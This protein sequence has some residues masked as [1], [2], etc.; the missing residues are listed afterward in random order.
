MGKDSSYNSISPTDYRYQ[1]D[2]LL[3]FLSEEAFVKYKSKVEAALALTLAKRRIISQENADKIVR[4]ASKVTAAE[5]YE[6]EKETRHDIIAQVNMI[7]KRLKGKAKS[8]VHMT[9]T[10]FDIVETANAMRYRDAFSQYIISDMVS[11]EKTWIEIARREKDTLQIGRTH[12]QHGEP[13]TYGFAMAWYVDRF[14][15]GILN[16][17]EAVEGLRGKFSGAVGAYN[18]S[19]L[20]VKDSEKF[21]K[22]VLARVGLKPAR[23]STQIAQPEPLAN[24]AHYVITSFGVLANFADDVR[25]LMMPEIAEVGLPRGQD[26]SR[27]STMPH[28]ANPI[29]PENVKSLWKLAKSKIESIYE[30]LISDFQRDL[31]NSASQRYVP[32]LFDVFD[33]AVTR[34]N[35]FSKSLKVHPYNMRRNLEMS[36]GIIPAE[37]LQ[38]LIASMG[39]HKAHKVIGELADKA[40]ETGESVVELAQ[41]DSR[42]SRYVKKIPEDQ[43][44]ILTDISLYRGQASAKA[45][46]I[47]DIWERKLKELNLW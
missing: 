10:S 30:D 43:M 6:E 45:Q 5:V 23:I 46:K 29:G 44:K 14:G 24:L 18:A 20:F 12:L 31:T 19:S 34:T 36:K 15:E 33:F 22:E 38:L 7:K 4:A 25:K 40:V 28:K 41:E 13:I 47:A 26:V 17:K 1:V 2:Y 16:V 9:A 27:S 32:E 3:P 35:R 42:L 39:Y 11:L 8:A 21:E 37:P